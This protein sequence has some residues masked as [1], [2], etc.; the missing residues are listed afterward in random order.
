MLTLHL[1]N[2]EVD[3]HTFASSLCLIKEL[4]HKAGASA[5]E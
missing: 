2:L 5:I 3:S 4:L 1:L